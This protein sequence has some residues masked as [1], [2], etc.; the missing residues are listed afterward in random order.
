MIKTGD[1]IPV[2][3]KEQNDVIHRLY[4]DEII[5]ADGR[6]MEVWE[7]VKDAD[8][9]QMFGW[10]SLD[11]EKLWTPVVQREEFCEK[12]HE[13]LHKG[14]YATFFL[15]KMDETKPATPGNLL[16]A[17]VRVFSG[18]LRVHEDRFEFD[19]VWDAGRRHRLVSPMN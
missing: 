2:V 16:V 4:A 7:L 14:G 9:S 13:K 8:F 1:G 15:H 3:E 11:L 12:H 5:V 17:S 18:G 6:T 19:Y 10:L